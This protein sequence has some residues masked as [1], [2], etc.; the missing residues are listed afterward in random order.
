M[1]ARA[2][3]VST[4][5][6]LALG[7]AASRANAPDRAA[8]AA[9]PAPRGLPPKALDEGVPPSQIER[10]GRLRLGDL[11]PFGWTE[12]RLRGELPWLVIDGYPWGSESLGGSATR[13]DEGWELD[14]DLGGGHRGEHLLLTVDVDAQGLPCAARLV[15]WTTF[16][17]IL[18]PR[19]IP[20]T[21]AG[22]QVHLVIDPEL[23]LAFVNVHLA[24]TWPYAELNWRTL[25]GT[26]HLPLEP[27]KRPSDR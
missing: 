21:L 25:A 5:G 1:P 14:L 19:S 4:I 11:D 10:A 17:H 27:A 6:V 9:A 22:G 16:G 15:E 3:I 18:G 26:L 2:L 12:A 23:D 7:R 13:T 20:V 8:T 24:G